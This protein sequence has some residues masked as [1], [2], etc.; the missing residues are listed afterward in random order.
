ML[1]NHQKK[2]I[3]ETVH[4]QVIK[5]ENEALKKLAED[6]KLP[7]GEVLEAYIDEYVEKNT[8]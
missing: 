7:F 3:Y 8:P 4:S 5:T 2:S 1:T 6:M